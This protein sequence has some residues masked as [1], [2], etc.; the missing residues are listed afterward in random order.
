MSMTKIKELCEVIE[1]LVWK[2]DIPYMDAIVLYCETN[3][4]E[5]ET[6]AKFVKNNDMLKARVQ[7]EAEGLN[8]LPKSSTLPID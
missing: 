8:Y 7:I 3:N 1:E 6:I 2:H 4:I 5:I